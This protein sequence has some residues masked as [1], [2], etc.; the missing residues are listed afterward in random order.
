MKTPTTKMS[1]NGQLVI[2]VK[3]RKKKGWKPGMRF[4]VSIEAGNVVL[5]PVQDADSRKEA[6]PDESETDTDEQD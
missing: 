5:K 3:I 6:K 1:I 4:L 2:P